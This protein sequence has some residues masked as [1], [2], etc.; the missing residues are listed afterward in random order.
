[1]FGECE[2]Y[3]WR[4]PIAGENT[5]VFLKTHNYNKGILQIIEIAGNSNKLRP[6]A[7]IQNIYRNLELNTNFLEASIMVII[8]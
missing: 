2:V 8:Y 6:N 7:M 3:M 5:L 4:E 1:M